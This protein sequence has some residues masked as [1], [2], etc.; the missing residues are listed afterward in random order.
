VCQVVCDYTFWMKQTEVSYKALNRADERFAVAILGGGTIGASWAALL[1]AH[2]YVVRLYEPAPAAHERTRTLIRRQLEQ[3]AAGP[4]GQAAEALVTHELRDALV[5][6]RLI[7][8][9]APERVEIKRSLIAEVEKWVSAEVVIASS[10]SALQPSQLQEGMRHPERLAVAHPFN[11][12]H[13]VPLVELVPGKQTHSTTVDA[14]EQLMRSLGKVTIRVKM[15]L[16][17][18]V[19]N[20]LTAALWRE[21]VY[22]VS[23]GAATVTDIDLAITSGPGLRWAT[24]GPHMAYHLAGGTGGI[25]HYLEHLGPT[26]EARWSELGSPKLDQT[27]RE[28]LIAGVRDEAGGRSIDDI[29]E[30]RDRH[31]LEI[32]EVF[33]RHFPHQPTGEHSG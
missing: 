22:L 2:G 4:D 33:K 21:A 28:L 1:L 31:L 16:T 3:L 20:R 14:I 32:L 15:E 30:Q 25:R 26:Q 11:P 12:P 27:T 29:E 17:G 19:A 13:L 5:D 7:L 6:A 18:H 24:I 8:Q 23:I 10:S 9:C